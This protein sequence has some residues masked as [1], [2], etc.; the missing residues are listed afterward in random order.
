ME[1][2]TYTVCQEIECWNVDVQVQ[3]YSEGHL[4]L[5]G[6]KVVLQQNEINDSIEKIIHTLF[7]ITNET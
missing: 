7:I 6:Q 5:L 1:I 3:R 2:K 4:Y